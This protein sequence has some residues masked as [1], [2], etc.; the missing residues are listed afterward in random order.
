MN[1]LNFAGSIKGAIAYALMLEVTKEYEEEVEH[2]HTVYHS[3]F[4]NGMDP[5]SETYFYEDRLRSVV[6]N[7]VLLLVLFTTVVYG[8]LMSMMRRWLLG[9][10]K[11]EMI[12]QEAQ[13]S[14]KTIE[15]FDS[16]V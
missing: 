11:E 1:F 2:G 10:A 3:I 9:G 13:E 8:G 6:R 15:S 14:R 7:T 4:N 16:L 5:S 12:A